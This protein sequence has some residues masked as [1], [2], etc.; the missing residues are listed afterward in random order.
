[1]NRTVQRNA[2]I[3]ALRCSGGHPTA[4]EIYAVLKRDLPQISLATV[5]R[6]LE[7]M[8]ACGMLKKILSH[9][10]HARFDI[11]VTVHFHIVC[12][13]CGKVCNI[14]TSEIID[15]DDVISEKLVNSEFEDYKL[16]F[17]RYCTACS[18]IIAAEHSSPAEKR[19]VLTMFD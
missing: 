3:N 12:P 19:K 17:F 13:L 2:I 16:E 4:D 11:D 18:D 15:V 8:V 7:Q 9:G 5:Y 10:K 14:E 6:N 1:M